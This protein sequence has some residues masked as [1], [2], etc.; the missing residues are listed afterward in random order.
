M[1]EYINS[2][3][4]NGDQYDLRDSNAVSTLAQ[5][6]TS[7]QQ[8]QACENIGLSG[9]VKYNTE[10]TL[11]VAQKETAQKNIGVTYPCNPNL[12]D[13]WYFGNPVNQRG[14]TSYTGNGYTI[15]RF[16]ISATD[17]C[18]I[19]VVDGGLQLS[20]SNRT[21]SPVLHQRIDNYQH[22][23]GKTITVSML[24]TEVTSTNG[25]Y[26]RFDVGN[27]PNVVSPKIKT[28]GLISA[29]GTISADDDTK[30]YALV[31]IGSN[32]ASINF[33]ATILA[34]KLELGTQ[35]TLAHQ[36]ADGNWVL[37]EIPD[38]GEQLARCQRYYHIYSSASARPTLAVDCSP[39][40]RTD[41]V[42][43]TITVGDTTYYANSADL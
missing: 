1:S 22:L 18:T 12:L 5:T 37:N 13:N 24:V 14:Q 26:I 10:Q 38:Y 30:G 21:W 35:Q 6:L 23:I 11:T 31:T 4:V 40:M 34:V 8:Q 19:S 42:Q 25:A 43:S 32:S 27:T 28:A 36:D 39:V 17:S 20:A 9:A 33:S 16:A 7:A 41:P 2:F 29:T 3:D 15:D